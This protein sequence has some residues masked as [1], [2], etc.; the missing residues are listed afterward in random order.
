VSAVELVSPLPPDEC[1]AC[2][3]GAVDLGLFFGF[4]SKP[5]IGR[6]FGWSVRLRKRI[7][8]SNSFQTFLIGAFEPHGGGSMFRGTAGVHPLVIAFVA[9]W[10]AGLVVGGGMF[11]VAAAQGRIVGNVPLGLALLPLMGVFFAVVV[12]FGRHL[13]RGER[14]FLLAFVA[15]LLNASG[16]GS[17]EPSAAADR[18]RSEAL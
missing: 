11:C 16:A 17:A 10:Y 1:V 13:A 3:R 9:V 7:G 8:Y 4:G 2:L 18:G 6:V 15:D 12:W 5:V 14:R